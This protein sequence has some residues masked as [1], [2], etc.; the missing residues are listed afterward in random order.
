MAVD[1]AWWL[2]LA[3]LAG[4]WLASLPW[5]IHVTFTFLAQ[6]AI[7]CDCFSRTKE[8]FIASIACQEQAE[9]I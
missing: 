1:A 2:L 3:G 4:G 6:T 7:S 9:S 8:S 5:D